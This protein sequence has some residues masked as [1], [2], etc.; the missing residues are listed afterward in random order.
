MYRRASMR[1]R[2]AQ[3][4]LRLRSRCRSAKL[5]WHH[6]E[7]SF[8]CHVA[9]TNLVCTSAYGF[10]RFANSWFAYTGFASHTCAF[11]LR[12]CMLGPENTS[13]LILQV[14]KTCCCKCATHGFA[15]M[16][17]F[18]SIFCKQ[19]TFFLQY[20]KVC[21][22]KYGTCICMLCVMQQLGLQNLQ[23]WCACWL[24]S[25]LVF[26]Q[27]CAFVCH[28]AVVANLQVWVG[29]L[30]DLVCK[31]LDLCA[32]LQALFSDLQTWFAILQNQRKSSS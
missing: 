31:R 32:H 30:A 26:L 24:F 11:S 20:F 3:Q 19:N 17:T 21:V 18:S 1:R 9:T 13:R 8:A 15:H 5:L 12:M 7:R 22:H 6:S 4:R 10:A 27:T 25:R 2:I 14:C 16:E 28:I 29:S 23:H